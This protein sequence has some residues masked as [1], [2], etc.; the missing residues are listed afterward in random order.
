MLPLDLPPTLHERVTCS[1]AAATKYEIPVNALLAVAEVEGGKPGQWVRNTNGTHD[2]GAMQFN[3]AY[4][5]TLSKYGIGA[6]HVAAPGCYS[7]EL[8]AWR[9][10]QHIVNDRG[11]FWSKIA[12]YHS[13]TPKYNQIYR[14]KLVTRAAKW[15]EWLNKRFGV[16]QVQRIP[17][18]PIKTVRTS[19]QSAA[20]E[21]QSTKAHTNSYVPRQIAV[22]EREPVTQDLTV[23]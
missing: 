15:G 16:G 8:A 4:L 19:V 17:A 14:A 10:R 12:N 13:R 23:Q 11:E 3:T 21:V 6:E 20:N 5:K 2:V 18:A 9:L 22:I 7:Y 1:I